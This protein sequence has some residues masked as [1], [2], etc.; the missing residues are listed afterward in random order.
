MNAE[1]GT[2]PYLVD[3]KHLSRARRPRLFWLSTG[4][5]KVEN[6]TVHEKE[7]LTRVVYE[8]PTEPL[9]HFLEEGAEWEAGL[10]DKEARF[11]TFTRSIPR[12]RP[13][14]NPVGLGNIDEA[15]K[16]RWEDHK[17][18]YP[19]YTYASEHMVL[20]KSL[21]LRP[22]TSGE[23]EVLMGYPRGYTTKLWKKTPSTE[24]EKTAAEDERSAAIGNSFHTNAV[25]CLLDHALFSVN[26]KAMKGAKAIVEASLKEQ[27]PPGASAATDLGAVSE[28][29]ESFAAVQ[30]VPTGAGVDDDDDA[31]SLS[32]GLASEV[33]SHFLQRPEDQT[34]ELNLAS[35]LVMAYIRRQEYRGSDVRLDIGSLYRADSWPRATINPGKW[36][37]RVAHAYA[38]TRPEHIN[39]LELRAI[40]HSF[41][42]RLRRDTY[43]DCR[44][45]H[46]SDSQVALAVAV[47]GRSSSRVI[48]RL[49]RRFAALQIAGGIHP[50]L[51]WVES[52]LNPADEPSR[53]HAT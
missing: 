3:S 46:L 10:R 5:A 12:R 50:L 52:E 21:N 34:A 39:L 53:R 35:Q 45:L 36:R 11:P 8:A 28:G 14:P 24:E 19:P 30:N 22:V 7:F 49:L 23:R 15:A 26:L 29:E 38:F 6:V 48:N 1:L 13:P 40:I 43:G 31:E 42:W 41:E 16:L 27:G 25:A 33:R 18:R 32:W 20:D 17:F 51:A 47:K 37:W 2:I 9:E 44:S 4:L